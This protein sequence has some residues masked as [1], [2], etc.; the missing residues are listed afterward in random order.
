MSSFP[1]NLQRKYM[2]AHPDYEPAAQPVIHLRDGGY[3]TLRPTKGWA[4]F[5][6][7]RL[8]AEQRVA[9]IMDR[10]LPD[11]RRKPPRIYRKAM[12]V[13]PATETRQQRRAATRK[14]AKAARQ[15]ALAQ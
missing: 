3:Y 15:K 6:A 10:V 9:E 7:K 1:R 2:R 11:R 14:A 5:T 4:R 13:P 8:R 12:P